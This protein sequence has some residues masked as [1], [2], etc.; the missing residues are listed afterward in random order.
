M[1]SKRKRSFLKGCMWEFMCFF[2][3]GSMVYYLTGRWEDVTF[4]VVTYH[5]CKVGLYYLHERF[6]EGVKWGRIDD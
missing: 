2:I 1:K 5:L 4:V 6:W 3:L